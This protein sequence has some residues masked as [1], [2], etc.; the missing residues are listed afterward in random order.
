VAEPGIISSKIRSVESSLFSIN[1]FMFKD[2]KSRLENL[3][4]SVKYLP[5]LYLIM[6][7][8]F[9]SKK[10]YGK[11]ERMAKWSAAQRTIDGVHPP[12]GSELYRDKSN[13]R[14]LSSIA[15]QAKMRA[16]VAR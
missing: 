12:E 14:E 2:V 3:L 16:E 6:Q 4:P 5:L 1:L 11:G 7:T 9:T 10:D 13:H 15:E 8:A